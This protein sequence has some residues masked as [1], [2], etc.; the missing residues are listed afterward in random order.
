M[1][2]LILLESLRSFGA[3]RNLESAATLAYYGFLSLMPLLLLAIFVL[4]LVLRSSEQ[5]LSA[6]GSALTGLF[7]TFNLDL[8]GELQALAARKVWGVVSVVV[9]L[10][11][12]TPF[13]AAAR[14]IVLR[15]FTTDQRLN[16]VKSKLLSVSAL[17]VL[18]TVLLL[19][20]PL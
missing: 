4:W 2:R 20:G 10:W 9:L 7:P 13:A 5:V 3:N 1:P 19:L 11:S 14:S 16:V 6:L 18:L 12:M 15:T 8:L 17:L